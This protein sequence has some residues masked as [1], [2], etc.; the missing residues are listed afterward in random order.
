[1]NRELKQHYQRITKMGANAF[2]KDKTPEER[3]KIMSAR[4]KKG[5]LKDKRRVIH[6]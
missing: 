1:M 4:R 6:K 3:S 2:W 5:W